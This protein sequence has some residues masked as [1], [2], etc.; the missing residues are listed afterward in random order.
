MD[1]R[2]IHELGASIR[3]QIRVVATSNL[4]RAVAF[5]YMI[6][7]CTRTRRYGGAWA[8]FTA[9]FAALLSCPD[10]LE[11]QTSDR[12]TVTATARIAFMRH[13]SKKLKT[14]TVCL[15]KI[16]PRGTP[17]TR[18]IRSRLGAPSE[19]KKT[20]G[21]FST[22]EI[23][24]IAISREQPAPFLEIPN[25]STCGTA[26]IN[27]RSIADSEISCLQWWRSWGSN[28]Q[29]HNWSLARGVE[30]RQPPHSQAG[31]GI[32]V[33]LFKFSKRTHDFMHP[34][35]YAFEGGS[36]NVVAGWGG[37]DARSWKDFCRR[38]G[39]KCC[40]DSEQ[41]REMIP[42]GLSGQAHWSRLVCGSCL[43]WSGHRPRF[44]PVRYP[45]RINR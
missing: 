12:N 8:G 1:C 5:P 10:K 9:G 29:P 33:N 40:I 16:T 22:I 30:Y 43:P 25:T 34:T 17:S 15:Q 42:A 21:S 41:T 7:W 11:T 32:S 36:T 3:L 26:S 31:A 37:R 45:R 28:S 39:A 13:T 24:S 44:P 27:I 14:A 6:S 4:W 19:K 18:Q 2:S 23:L 38:N 20:T 35:Y